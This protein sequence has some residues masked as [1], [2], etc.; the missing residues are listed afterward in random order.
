MTHWHTVWKIIREINLQLD[1][2]KSFLDENCHCCFKHVFFREIISICIYVLSRKFNII[3]FIFEF[4]LNLLVIDFTKKS[5]LIN[6]SVWQNE[7]FTEMQIFFRQIN[8]IVKFFSKTLIWRNFCKKTVP[9]KFLN[10]H[11][12]YLNAMH[13]WIHLKPLSLTANL[14]TLFVLL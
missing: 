10:V 14:R 2:W 1:L 6:I 11:S 4:E 13:S 7:K 8:S 5:T 3:A 9:V 12:V